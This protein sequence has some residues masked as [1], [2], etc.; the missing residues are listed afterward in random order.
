VISRHWR[1]LALQN[2][3]RDYIHH[4]CAET[5]P[6]LRKLPGFVDASIHSRSLGAGVE[7]LIVTRW[8]SVDAIARFAGTDQE[9][10]V[11]PTEVAQMMIEYDHRARHFEVLDWR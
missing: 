7:F 2:R 4:L 10:A 9:A 8:D 11:V 6:A 5:F 1:G 3:A